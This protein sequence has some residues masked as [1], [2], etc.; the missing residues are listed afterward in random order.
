MHI[1][2]IDSSTVNYLDNTPLEEQLFGPDFTIVR[3]NRPTD[4]MLALAVGIVAFHSVAVDKTLLAKLDRCKAIVKATVGID[5]VDV[6][7]ATRKGILCAHLQGIGADEVADHTM[8]F[9]LAAQRQLFAYS[10]HTKKGHWSWRHPGALKSCQ[11]TVLGLLGFGAIGRRVAERAQVFGYQIR[12]FD[13]GADMAA[14]AQPA[15]LDELLRSA[16]IVSIHMP[17]NQ[18]NRGFFNWELFSRCKAGMC[19]VN[20]SRGAL[21]DGSDLE[22]ALACGRVAGAYLDVLDSE[23]VPSASLRANPRVVLTPHAAFYSERSLYELR[24]GAARALHDMLAHGWT[25]NLLNK[26]LLVNEN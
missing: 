8:A 6:A 10:E 19:L 16:D 13:P 22:R 4:E 14:H 25:S 11:D 21:V 23:P 12:H 1:L 26:E 24:F 2:L 20:T 15:T 9:I 18:A 17:L 7:A 3:T 5:D